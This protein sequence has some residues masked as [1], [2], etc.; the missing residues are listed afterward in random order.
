MND[1]SDKHSGASVEDLS[2]RMAETAFERNQIDVLRFLGQ[3]PGKPISQLL[4]ILNCR[5]NV[6]GIVI[7]A[8]NAAQRTSSVRE[9]SFDLLTRQIIQEY[10][11]GWQ[12]GSEIHTAVMISNCFFV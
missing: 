7:A 12:N 1:D 5:S 10:P 4:P 6:L 8:Y 11:A 3:H 9:L 2:L